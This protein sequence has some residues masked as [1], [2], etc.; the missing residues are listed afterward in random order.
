MKLKLKLYTNWEKSR[1]KCIISLL[2]KN[3]KADV[4]DLGCGSGNFTLELKKTIRCREILGI[5]GDYKSL[6]EAKEKGIKTFKLDIDKGLLLPDN[7][8]DVIVSNQVIEHLCYPVQFIKE[9]WRIL[10][11]NG[12][13]VISTE[14]LSSWDNIF[15]LVLGYTP[16]SMGFDS[17]LCKIGNPLSLHDRELKNCGFPH[18]RIF[19]WGGL[20]ELVKFIG[21]KIEKVIGSG[22]T[23]G[24]LG[25]NL[26]PRHCRFITIKVRK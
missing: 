22:H 15:A 12:Y 4:V 17:G 9:V 11:P 1:N 24:K 18:V 21:F 8:F 26:D 14:N 2:E 3:P 16:F 19:A 5:D 25:E 20:V 13:A 6:T 10:K 7:R 23:L